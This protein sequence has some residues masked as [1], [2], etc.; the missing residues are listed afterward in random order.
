[1]KIY[2][3]T[4]KYQNIPPK[5]YQN[6]T[7]K[8]DKTDLSFCAD[9]FIKNVEPTTFYRI[10]SLEFT[11][12]MSIVQA[13]YCIAESKNKTIQDALLY[14]LHSS[15]ELKEIAIEAN[16]NDFIRNIKVKK[17]IGM[18]G[19]AFVFETTKNNALKIVGMEHFPNKREPEFFDLP[20]IKKGSLGRGKYY[21]EE[22]AEMNVTKEEAFNLLKKIKDFG[23]KINDCF[24]LSG[25]I[26]FREDILNK[27]L[28]KLD[29][30]GRGKDGKV[31]LLDPGCAI[32]PLKVEKLIDKIK[33]YIK[34][35]KK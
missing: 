24:Y 2:P 12:P 35:L 9:N 8:G 34:R 16:S 29:Q 25:D 7:F 10:K 20:I 19:F 13:L 18:G 6:I 11:K 17:L 21:I 32:A 14:N 3:T 28:I 33:N 5:H 15:E 27:E 23:F 22:K 4:V 1:M 30:F 26:Q 31:Y